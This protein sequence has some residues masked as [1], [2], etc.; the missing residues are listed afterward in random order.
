MPTGNLYRT[1]LV[2]LLSVM[3]AEE[4]VNAQQ[5]R[6]RAVTSVARRNQESSDCNLS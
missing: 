2:T 3:S 1:M 5:M 6:S 4:T